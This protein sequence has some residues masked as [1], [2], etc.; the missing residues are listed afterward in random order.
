MH[1]LPCP[2][3]QSSIRVSPSQAGDATNC[4]ACQTSVVI[5]RLG[6]LRKLPQEEDSAPS[7]SHAAVA[8]GAS[9]STWRRVT[10]VILGL[11]A[12]ASLL[13]AGFCG[14]RWSLIDNPFSTE[15]H[16][17]TIRDQYSGLSAAQLIRE[18]E[19]MDRYGLDLAAPY[20]Y[21]VTES[22]KNQWGM[23]AVIAA[24]VGGLAVLGAIAVSVS[25]RRKEG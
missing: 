3:C 19:E 1:L 5:P 12:T 22:I 21:K 17:A 6:D 10:F 20:K 25:G 16:I 4:P 9:T 23:N 14:L 24:G 18:Y 15:V 7:G 13:I 11:I 8:A 2:S